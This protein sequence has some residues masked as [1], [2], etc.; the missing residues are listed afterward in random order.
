MPPKQLDFR[1]VR[2]IATALDDVQESTAYGAP[3][4]KVRGRLITCPAIHK[5]AEADSL[6]A[7][8]GFD[9]RDELI[10]ADPGVYYLTDHYVDHPVVLVRLPTIRRDSLEGVL[11]MAWRFVSAKAPVRRRARRE[12]SAS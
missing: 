4:F 11:Q 10:A 3:A 6:V 5:S 1:A 9:Q 7:C 8:V 12:P 2:E